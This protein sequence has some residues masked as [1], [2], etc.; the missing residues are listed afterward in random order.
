MLLGHTYHS[1]KYSWVV[2]AQ[3]AEWQGL[4]WAAAVHVAW[5][6]AA[7]EAGSL[8]Q[9]AESRTANGAGSTGQE[10]ESRVTYQARST[11]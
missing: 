11:G 6:R 7:N 8:G 2:S 3:S 5:S 4:T 10:T 1:S 9:G